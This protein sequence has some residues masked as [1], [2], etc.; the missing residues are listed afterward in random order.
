MKI[1]VQV[2]LFFTF[3]TCRLSYIFC[4]KVT[5]IFQGNHWVRLSPNNKKYSAMSFKT[6]NVQIL[7][8]IYKIRGKK[9]TPIKYEE[10]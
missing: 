3:S 10:S 1:L 5:I 7:I 4:F 9:R 8:L 2:V 6:G